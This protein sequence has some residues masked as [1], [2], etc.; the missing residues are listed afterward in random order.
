MKYIELFAGCGGM[1]LGL[2]AAGFELFLANELSPMA[3]QTYAYNI[4]GADLESGAKPNVNW[5]SSSFPEDEMILRLREPPSL[6]MAGTHCDFSKK[7]IGY[8]SLAIGSIIGLNKLAS[9][10]SKAGQTLRRDLKTHKIDLIS[11]GPPCQSFSLA[12]R[13]DPKNHRNKLPAEFCKFVNCVRPR[14]VILENVSGILRPFDL[15]GSKYYAWFEVAKAFAKIGYFPLCM[16]INAKDVGVPQ[17]RPRFIMLGISGSVFSNLIPRFRDTDPVLTNV[18]LR[19]Q[20]FVRAA[21]S[22]AVEL[23]QLDCHDTLSNPELFESPLFNNFK[24]ASKDRVV[25]VSAAIGDLR[26]RAKTPPSKYVKDLNTNDFPPPADFQ[27]S[28]TPE[29]QEYRKHGPRVK[30]RFRLLQVASDLGP[31]LESSVIAMLKGDF[32]NSAISINA[33][34]RLQTWL[35]QPDGVRVDKPSANRIRLIAEHVGSR[36]HSQRALLAGSPAPATMSIP[37]DICHYDSGDVRTLTAREMARIQSFPDWFVFKSKATTG[38]TNRRFEVPQYTQI[39]NA[40]PPLLAK[41]LGQ[42]V[43][44]LLANT[45]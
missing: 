28:R 40:V 30:A 20:Q 1:S 42:L 25:P 43:S 9:S 15:D 6:A 23:D 21:R 3:G 37:D 36:K 16:H 10:R 31:S 38:G 14:M 24:N 7:P 35:Y 12:G 19:V 34:R 45:K 39:G 4:L 29:N 27:Y 33:I 44:E 22:E 17:N 11:G 2:E 41:A 26:Q 18:L 8:P 5:I 32:D 13:R